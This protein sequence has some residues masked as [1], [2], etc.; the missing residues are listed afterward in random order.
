MGSQRLAYGHLHWIL[1]E[2]S[3]ARLTDSLEM[4][5]LFKA[6]RRACQS[7]LHHVRVGCNIPNV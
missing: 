7:K 1:W 6:R 3:F 4:C 2:A 5:T